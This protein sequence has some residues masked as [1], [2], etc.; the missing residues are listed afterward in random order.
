MQ[1][2]LVDTNTPLVKKFEVHIADRDLAP[3]WNAEIV[4][5]QNEPSFLPT[6]LKQGMLRNVPSIAIYLQRV[7]TP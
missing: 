5:S 2:D 3:S 7:S 4:V 1:G 6:S